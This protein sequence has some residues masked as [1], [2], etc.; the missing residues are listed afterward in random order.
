MYS[1]NARA[2]CVNSKAALGLGEAIYNA[3][4]Y[5]H[6]CAF[7]LRQ[8]NRLHEYNDVYFFTRP[9]YFIIDHIPWSSPYSLLDEP[10]T[11]KQHSTLRLNSQ[12]LELFSSRLRCFRCGWL[13]AGVV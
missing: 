10:L 1:K 7:V 11:W 6:D 3:S 9:E 5:V 4:A 8:N 12:C 13:N 2:L